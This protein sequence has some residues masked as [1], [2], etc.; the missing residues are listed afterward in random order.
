VSAAK[1]PARAGGGPE[2]RVLGAHPLEWAWLGV[3]L[4]LVWRYRFLLDD[5]FV[6]F[7][8]VDNLLF[9][10][11]GLVYNAGEYVEGFSSPLWTLLLIPLRAAG[12]GWSALVLGV[13]LAS[14][15]AFWALAVRANRALAGP[16]APL[17]LPTA[18]L[19]LLYAVPTWFTS[20]LESPLVHL[21]AAGYALFALFPAARAW[22]LVVALSPLVRHELLVPWA[23]AFAWAWLRSGRPPVFLA[24][25]TALPL[26]AW[27]G[28]RIRYYADLFPNTF[29]LKD[30]AD[31][32]QGLAYLADTAGPYHLGALAAGLAALALALRASGGEARLAER[33]AMLLLALPVAL[34]VVRIGGASIHYRYLAF[35]FCL[36]LLAGAGLPEQAL[37][38]FA[39]RAARVAAPALGVALAALSLSLYP[40]QLPQHPLRG[41]VRS[42][43]VAKITDAGYHR[44]RIGDG[45]RYTSGL[46]PARLREYRE[47]LPRFA[48]H[49]VRVTRWCADGYSA[50]EQRVI[51]AYG[52]TDAVLAR[53]DTPP[54][55]PAHKPRLPHMA[56]GL[57]RI[58]ERAQA[59]GHEPGP[60]LFREAAELGEAPGWVASQLATLEVIERKIFNRHHPVENLALALAF[61]PRLAP[62]DPARRP[63][64]SPTGRSGR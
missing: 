4:F 9:L 15:A 27:L 37:R 7:R 22:Q 8:Y 46:T 45:H 49:G 59:R 33:G 58:F 38:R 30:L 25:A 11:V 29:Y 1:A 62:P 60:G 44:W 14:Y 18:G 57:G 40:P 64:A 26:A 39:P 24:V 2:V 21:C 61:P 20:G 48:Y 53:V 54:G 5:A 10:R 34:Y 32:S 35:P 36:L 28:F 63:E 52:L 42:G 31:W 43:D 3:G 56:R 19:G 55:R 17:S 41:A 6:Y 47:S 50:P 16:G 23:L 13:G 51:I 12:L